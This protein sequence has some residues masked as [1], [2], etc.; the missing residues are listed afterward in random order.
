MNSEIGTV[1]V[2]LN[3]HLMDLQYLTDMI[4]N[5]LFLFSFFPELGRKGE[6]LRTGRVLSGPAD[7]CFPVQCH[8]SAL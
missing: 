8:E 7:D 2:S 6:W 3:E 4:S 1:S 5:I